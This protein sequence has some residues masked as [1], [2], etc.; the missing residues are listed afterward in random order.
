M[1]TSPETI[2]NVH[3]DVKSD[4]P[5]YRDASEFESGID[6]Q[7]DN[8]NITL[9]AGTPLNTL[10]ETLNVA[11]FFKISYEL[12]AKASVSP[13]NERI[14]RRITVELWKNG[15]LLSTLNRINMLFDKRDFVELSDVSV[16]GAKG[17]VFVV[18]LTVNYALVLTNVKQTLT[19]HKT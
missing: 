19:I 6:T 4:Q 9:V 16:V 2:K 13:P 15:T 7:T 14:E 8:T 12:S 3:H 18:R 17:D 1:N 10:T 11:G 5:I